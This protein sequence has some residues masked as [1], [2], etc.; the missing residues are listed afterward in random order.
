MFE[1][2]CVLKIS[3]R[4]RGRNATRST[5]G[6][7]NTSEKVAGTELLRDEGYVFVRGLFYI[8]H[9]FSSPAGLR[10]L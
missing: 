2:K 3:R 7:G 8:S 4:T 6:H 9:A 5:Q 10:K 1:L